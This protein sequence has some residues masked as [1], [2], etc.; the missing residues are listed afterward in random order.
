MTRIALILALAACGSDKNANPTEPG[1]VVLSWDLTQSDRISIRTAKQTD[2]KSQE[3]DVEQA[4]D[5]EKKIPVKV[6]SPRD[7]AT[8]A[9][10][11]TAAVGTAR[12]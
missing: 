1:S 10:V 12:R 3:L 8:V 5:F 7:R 6:Q 11:M 9:F 2:V 4:V